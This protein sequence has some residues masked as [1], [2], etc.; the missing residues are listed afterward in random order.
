MNSQISQLSAESFD[1]AAEVFI[2][3]A[4]R[5]GGLATVSLRDL[6]PFQ[7]A[8]MV[9]DGTVTRFI[10]AYQQEPVNIFRLAQT[11]VRTVAAD[12]W[13]QVSAN[14]NVIRRQVLLRGAHT[15]RC[16]A[17]ADSCLAASRLTVEMRAGLETDPGGLG[18]MLLDS[19]IETRRECLWFG[20][21]QLL[22]IPEAVADGL[23]HDFLTRTYRVITNESPLMLITERFAFQQRPMATI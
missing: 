23:G 13:L 21:E 1:P 9:I 7:R 18:R 4:Q 20:R 16:F 3:Q 12:R 14:E 15:G 6:T 8:L 10:E 11:E 22:N 5:P 2:A 17:W 19:V